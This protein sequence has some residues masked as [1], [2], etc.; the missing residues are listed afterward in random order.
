MGYGAEGRKKSQ[1]SGRARL[2]SVGVEAVAS[3]SRF[4]GKVPGPGGA[5]VRAEHLGQIRRLVP[6]DM[7]DLV[8]YCRPKPPPLAAVGSPFPVRCPGARRFRCRSV[9]LCLPSPVKVQRERG[10]G[11][12][13]RR[14][15]RRAADGGPA[16]EGPRP[17]TGGREPEAPGHA[18][19]RGGA[20]HTEGGG[21]LTRP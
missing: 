6:N 5:P 15:N 12:R 17:T 9:C 19:P 16:A 2:Q 8:L 20:R 1:K 3:W 4:R 7:P 13:R 14:Q 11:T 18:H 21:A 10:A